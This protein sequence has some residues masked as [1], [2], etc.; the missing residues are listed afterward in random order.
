MTCL[1]RNKQ[2]LHN[3]HFTWLFIGSA[4]TNCFQTFSQ[5]MQSR[6]G[7]KR[8]L[9]HSNLPGCLVTTK[10]AQKYGQFCSNFGGMAVKRQH[11]YIPP[12]RP[13]LSHHL[14]ALDQIRPPIIFSELDV[15]FYSRRYA[16]PPSPLPQGVGC[17]DGASIACASQLSLVL[18]SSAMSICGLPPR[19]HIMHLLSTM[20]WP[21][22]GPQIPLSCRHQV[23]FDH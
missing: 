7:V 4:I 14:T 23:I 15:T 10:S 17:H 3:L 1:S 11:T 5:R 12:L 13:L 20:H 8:F 18:I 2:N 19:S 6:K 21:W 16:S 22:K 9:P